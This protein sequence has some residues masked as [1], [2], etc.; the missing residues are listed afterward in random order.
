MDIAVG[1]G[2][3]TGNGRLILA[4][5]EQVGVAALQ[6]E[7]VLYGDLAADGGDP[8]DFAVDGFEDREEPGLGGQTG[9]VYRVRGLRALSQGAG[10]EDEIGRDTS[11]LQSRRQ[12][13]CRLL[14]EK[15]K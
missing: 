2:L 3:D 8:G 5:P 14:L 1:N 9:Q 11:E 6:D 13:V 4:R 15:K 7:V 12:L 10:N